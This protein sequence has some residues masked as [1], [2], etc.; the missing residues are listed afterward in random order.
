MCLGVNHEVI[1][2]V[3]DFCCF[4]ILVYCS[5]FYLFIHSFIEILCPNYKVL[6]WGKGRGVKS[7]EDVYL[8]ESSSITLKVRF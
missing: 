6:V 4:V 8:S 7:F 5:I 3:A 2:N 1:L